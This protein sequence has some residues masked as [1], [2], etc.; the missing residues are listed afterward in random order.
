MRTS[1]KA[2]ADLYVRA[3]AAITLCYEWLQIVHS[4]ATPLLRPWLDMRA[5]HRCRPGTQLISLATRVAVLA[6]IVG[7]GQTR[8]AAGDDGCEGPGDDCV[9]I[10]RWN[11]SVA[12]GAGVRTN[13]LVNGKDIPL[14]VI[15][16]VSYY[17][18]RFFLDNLDVG[19]TV[20]ERDGNTFNLIATPGYDRVYFYRTDL[21][22]FFIGFPY[23]LEPDKAGLV[24]ASAPGATHV[25]RSAPR[26]TYLAGPEWTFKYGL[27]TGQLDLLRD[28]TGQNSGDEVRGALGMPL[29]KSK[30]TVSANIGFTWKSTAT[31]NYYYAVPNFYSGS[32]AFDPIVKLG[33][34]LPLSGKWSFNAFA[35][36]ERLGNSIADSPIVAEHSVATVFV[37]ATYTF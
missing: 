31:V 12:L 5:R 22:N 27:V 7:P 15:P 28:A 1:R 4:G 23:A 9:A 30:G 2:V 21:Q 20:Y 6:I 8:A 19:F 24:D 37:G 26:V 36:Y 3:T 10:G 33:Y 18:K 25:S 35:E 11:F 14:V 34:T 16:Q 32:A 17:G 29:L 13:P